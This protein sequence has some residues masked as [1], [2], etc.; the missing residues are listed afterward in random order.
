LS[1]P[2]GNAVVAR[3]LFRYTVAAGL[4]AS[5]RVCVVTLSSH[6]SGGSGMSARCRPRHAEYVAGHILRGIPFRVL[7][8]ITQDVSVELVIKTGEPF[9]RIVHPASFSSSFS[10]FSF[11]FVLV[12]RPSPSDA[13]FT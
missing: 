3:D 10:S 4:G 7:Q 1:G 6:G 12:P 2:V 9:R 8:G 11:F 13:A 5:V